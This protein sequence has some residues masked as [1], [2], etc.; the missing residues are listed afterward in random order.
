MKPNSQN[1]AGY[2]TTKSD[3]LYLVLYFAHMASTYQLAAL[4]K[5]DPA[6]IRRTCLSLEKRGMI[7]RPPLQF[8]HPNF[9]PETY[10]PLRSA[11]DPYYSKPAQQKLQSEEYCSTQNLFSIYALTTAS[12]KHVGELRSVKVKGTRY[13]W[14][15]KRKK[16]Y[17]ELPHTLGIT[18]FL[19]YLDIAAA[20]EPGLAMLWQSQLTKSRTVTFKNIY[21]SHN[22]HSDTFNPEPDAF[23]AIQHDADKPVYFMLE[24]DRNNE[25]Y[26]I[27][28]RIGKSKQSFYKT[29]L[30]KKVLLFDEIT[31]KRKHRAML[32]IPHFVRLFV[33]LTPGRAKKMIK[34]IEETSGK[35][36]RFYYVTDVHTLKTKN[37]LDK[38][39]RVPFKSEPQALPTKPKLIC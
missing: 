34:M 29:T 35:Y 21:I 16:D 39:W 24:Y 17:Y 12:A 36:A 5:R 18:D 6:S 11:Y 8:T 9:H 33:A 4:L 31:R 32:D 20:A 3:D 13:N 15:N 30:Q 23:F 27:S 19:I 38:V 37:P 28:H 22:G 1:Q 7:A 10:Q 26:W 2:N 14:N 25:D